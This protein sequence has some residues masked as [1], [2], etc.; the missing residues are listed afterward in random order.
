MVRTILQTGRGSDR[1]DAGNLAAFAEH[2]P[3]TVTIA[4]YRTFLT[5]EI[6]PIARGRYANDVLQCA[7]H[8]D[9]GRRRSGDQRH[10]SGPR[11]AAAA[12][13]NP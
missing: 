7:D 5:R 12:R 10:I 6:V 2:V 13:P 4:M 8:T 11:T 3:A 9:R 1:L